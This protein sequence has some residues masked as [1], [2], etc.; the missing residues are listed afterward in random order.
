MFCFN[1]LN[2]TLQFILSILLA[3][4][5]Q[6][7]TSTTYLDSVKL[8]ACDGELASLHC[9]PYHQIVIESAN[10]GRF[11]LKECNPTRRPD[12]NI[13]CNNPE[14]IDVLRARCEHRQRC[15]V[16]VNWA[17]F[18]LNRINNNESFDQCP[19]T[20][21][22]LDAVYGCEHQNSCNVKAN[23]QVFG[24]KCP[25]V[26]KYLDVVYR[27]IETTTTTSSTSTTTK[28]STP[29]PSSLKISS[30]KLEKTSSNLPL[31]NEYETTKELL[32]DTYEVKNDGGDISDN[33]SVLLYLF[34]ASISAASVVFSIFI[35]IWAYLRRNR[36]LKETKNK[37]KKKHN[38]SEKNL[39]DK[40]EEGNYGDYATIPYEE[41]PKFQKNSPQTLSYYSPSS[42]GSSSTTTTA[43][44]NG[45]PIRLG[46]VNGQNQ[47]SRYSFN[48]CDN[49]INM[50]EY[51]QMPLQH[52]GLHP[53]P[54]C[55]PIPPPN[56]P[57][58]R[59]HE[60][61]QNYRYSPSSSLRSSGGTMV[62]KMDFSRQR[63]LFSE[64]IEGLDE[65]DEE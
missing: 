64:R 32:L 14:A 29:K 20:P 45:Y 34:L 16:P 61:I 4:L 59:G 58:N 62:V 54:P 53:I 55:F 23:I 48:P 7:L 11:A 8:I 40:Q 21:K 65:M 33:G 31:I 27:C 2:Y 35:A 38:L 39:L 5:P 47:V 12:F 17:I 41:I 63:P 57:F 44:N 10:F 18:Q 30:N 25:Q 15:V 37:K 43:T 9:P 49:L 52:Y 13:F 51:G 3:Y 26:N 19:G 46:F 28:L 22:Y 56:M 36:R 50:P 24:N 6:I 42:S 60:H 1:S